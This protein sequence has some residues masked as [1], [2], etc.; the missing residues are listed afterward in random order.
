M[1]NN[2]LCRLKSDSIS[3]SFIINREEIND[4]QILADNFN[5][6]IYK[7]MRPPINKF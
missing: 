3:H 5:D 2:V 1:I 4:P 6:F 7:C